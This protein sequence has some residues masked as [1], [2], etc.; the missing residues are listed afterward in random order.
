MPRVLASYIVYYYILSKVYVC[1]VGIVH[2]MSK[3]SF[4]RQFPTTFCPK[5]SVHHFGRKLVIFWKIIWN[6]W[7]IICEKLL[8]L[9]V[10][11]IVI[12]TTQ[13]YVC[14]FIFFL[15][16][17]SLCWLYNWKL[18]ERIRMLVL[19]ACL[20]CH[21]CY[22]WF[23]HQDTIDIIICPLHATKRTVS[24]YWNSVKCLYNWVCGKN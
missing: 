6:L 3:T 12:V 24:T 18:C 16:G 10:L 14:L 21:I 13:K 7:M 9:L 11:H 5:W 1:F 8:I 20:L 15:F 19:S 2:W 17:S 22:S 23:A 4:W